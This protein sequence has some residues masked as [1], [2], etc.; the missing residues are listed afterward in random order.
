MTNACERGRSRALPRSRRCRKRPATLRRRAPQAHPAAPQAAWTR[1]ARGSRPAEPGRRAAS[2]HARGSAASAA[3]PSD[4]LDDHRDG[5]PKADAHAGDAVA[6]VAALEL[7]QEGG[8]YART[9]R[10]ERMPERDAAAVRVDVVPPL[11]Q[12]RVVHELKRH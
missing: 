9:G 4:A 7:V 12:T 2:R 6:G 8:G 3:V 1:S 11:L 5:L 10:A